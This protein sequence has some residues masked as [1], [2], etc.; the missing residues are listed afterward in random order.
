MPKITYHEYRPGRWVKLVDGRAVGPASAEEVAQWQRE[1]A[2]QAR[3]WQ[4]VLQEA[5]EDASPQSRPAAVRKGE[6]AIWQDVVGQIEG[7]RTPPV[8]PCEAKEPEPPPR[9]VGDAIQS[10]RRGKPVVVRDGRVVTGGKPVQPE[11]PSVPP[12]GRAAAAEGLP[13]PE[14]Q[15][16]ETPVRRVKAAPAKRA[17]KPMHESADEAGQRVAKAPAVRTAA[18]PTAEHGGAVVAREEARPEPAVETVPAPKPKPRGRRAEATASAKATQAEPPPAIDMDVVEQLTEP[19]QKL[20]RSMPA[21]ATAELTPVPTTEAAP[22]AELA[23]RAPEPAEPAEEETETEPVSVQA[24]GPG[25]KASEPEAQPV[26]QIVRP[27]RGTRSGRRATGAAREREIGRKVP[28][29]TLGPAYLWIMAGP[30]DDVVAAVRGGLARYEER[31]NERAGAVLCHAEDLPA[32][33]GATLPV[34][35]RPRKGVPPRNFWIG[36]K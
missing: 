4:D 18:G 23:I 12:A 14:P 24:V 6:P 15:L 36:P 8:P 25:D 31:F 27:R 5:A 10:A 29:D 17:A 20:A 19:V 7:P 1:K 13:K 28:Q 2:E 34:D 35:V 33:E 9:T 32:L 30:S 21:K 26:I 11:G 22:A 16:A 3:I